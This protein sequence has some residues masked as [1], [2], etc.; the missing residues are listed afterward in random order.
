MVDDRPEGTTRD[1]V[2]FIMAKGEMDRIQAYVD[3]GRKFERLSDERLRELMVPAYKA[4][5]ANVSDPTT[6]ELTNDIGAEFAMRG[7][8]P[9]YDLVA[10]EID[11]GCEAI[12]ALT[13]QLDDDRIA[14]INSEM[15]QDYIDAHR[16]KN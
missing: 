11:R 3:R 8:T 4:W 10:E 5:A 9:P 12:A 1:V 7:V 2:A 16:R 14:A 6:G 13:A 15:C